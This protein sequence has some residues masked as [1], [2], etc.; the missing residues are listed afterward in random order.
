MTSSRAGYGFSRCAARLAGSGVTTAVHRCR[1]AAARTRFMPRW[2][3]LP[4]QVAGAL[5]LWLLCERRHAALHPG[6]HV[7]QR[8]RAVGEPCRAGPCCHSCPQPP[9]LLL[10]LLALQGQCWESAL[11][12][13]SKEGLPLRVA[14]QAGTG[15]LSK[16]PPWPTTLRR[17]GLTAGR[18]GAVGHRVAVLDLR[19]GHAAGAPAE[20]GSGGCAPGRS[21]TMCDNAGCQQGT[22]ACFSGCAACA[23]RTRGLRCL[24]ACSAEAAEA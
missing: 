2:R 5:L 19:H 11:P 10:Q 8:S 14:S 4:A 24:P 18:T 13:W 17:P 3:G 16:T 7:L 1:W 6:S 21:P 22:L 15:V 20:P 23:R 12:L 9:P